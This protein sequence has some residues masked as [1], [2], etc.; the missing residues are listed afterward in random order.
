MPA[1]RLLQQ[2]F[3]SWNA[4][5]RNYMIGREFWS[6]EETRRAG[7]SMGKA[8]HRLR[9]RPDSPWRTIPWDLDLTPKKAR[10]T[11]EK[12]GSL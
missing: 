4:L 6:L 7:E 10:A 1:A 5:G 3:D 9:T 8:F 2:T 11:A 12:T